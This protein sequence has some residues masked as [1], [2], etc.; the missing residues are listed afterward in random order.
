MR[1]KNLISLLF[2]TAMFSA[3]S[4]TLKTQGDAEDY[5]VVKFYTDFEGIQYDSSTLNNP[6]KYKAAKFLGTG[7]FY[8]KNSNLSS[9][10]QEEVADVR[11]SDFSNIDRNA[12]PYVSERKET[13]AYRY[14]FDKF[15]GFY[16]DGTPVVMNNITGN[17]NV[18]SHFE[19]VTKNY[20][21]RVFTSGQRLIFTGNVEYGT[22]VGDNLSEEEKTDLPVEPD[23]DP[24]KTN[25]AYYMVYPFK[26][27]Q[28]TIADDNE[29]EV[30]T[31]LLSKEQLLNWT[32]E[33]KIS[34]YPVFGDEEDSK[35]A[36]PSY[37]PYYKDYTIN[38]YKTNVF[39]P[40]NLIKSEEYEWGQ[41]LSSKPVD[42][43]ACSEPVDESFTWEFKSWVGEYNVDNETDP[44]VEKALRTAGLDGELVPFSEDFVRYHCN[45]YP[46]YEKVKKQ[47]KFT[48]YI[49]P[50]Y[51]ET[52][53]VNLDYGQTDYA[54]PKVSDTSTKCFTGRW[55]L[56]PTGE[57]MEQSELPVKEDLAIYAEFVDTDLVLGTGE[58]LSFRKECFIDYDAN[59]NTTYDRGYVLE[60]VPD[61]LHSLDIASLQA[62]LPVPIK[63]INLE[64]A[65]HLTSITLD[66]NI[67]CI[68]ANSFRG[69]KATS[70]DLSNASHLIKI[71]AL[72]FSY[73]DALTSLTLPASIKGLG[74]G[75]IQGCEALTTIN[76]KMS[77]ANYNSYESSGLISSK[78]NYVDS[79]LKVDPAFI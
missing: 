18:F 75:I 35:T 63:A 41:P 38:Y 22:K 15:V 14:K 24:E 4:C 72:A 56:S 73:A 51:T 30:K 55:K 60:S 9:E 13:K 45:V 62:G 68:Y 5:Y 31:P 29:E 66:E 34:F 25:D 28:G 47:V 23:H 48:C 8:K 10:Q 50:D 12:D 42:A 67:T 69:I 26:G 7:Y 65:T 77:E 6:E 57:G 43:P 20:L 44:R 33:D 64:D 2:L 61:T 46:L 52:K 71:D 21:L 17:C 76:L 78:W 32:V 74:K 16:G 3:T 79:V 40:E 11:I 49:N 27:Y 70:L 58:K 36:V 37:H 1:K 19:E 39:T 53:E 54:L 59:S